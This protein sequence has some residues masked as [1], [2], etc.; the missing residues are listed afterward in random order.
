[1]IAP[2]LLSFSNA[3]RVGM[4]YAISGSGLLLGGVAMTVWGGP[5][6]R[7]NGVLIFSALAGT[8]AAAHG[9]RP[10]F[11]LIAVAGF[12]LFLM[13]PVIAASSSSLWQAKVPAGLQ[14]RCFA[15]Q[16]AVFYAS[17]VFGYFLAGPVS[18]RVFE[19]LLARGGPLAGSVGL[20]IGVGPGRGLG[21]MFIILGTVMTLTAL[22]AYSVPAIRQ[23]DEL[24]D[25]FA[26]PGKAAPAG[27]RSA[28]GSGRW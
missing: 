8:C 2:L 9:L 23:L 10:S 25:T 21:L 28:G 7:I 12:V 15:I 5:R 16:R 1:V 26:L 20:I 19:P 14:G 18:E 17:T 22:T 4:Q 24:A 3:S 11:T 6:K 27:T 13:L